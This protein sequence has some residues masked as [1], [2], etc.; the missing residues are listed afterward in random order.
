MQAQTTLWLPAAELYLAGGRL[1]DGIA[2]LRRLLRERLL[3]AEGWDLLANA[4]ERAGRA[5][6]AA[7]AR[8]NVLQ[9]RRD[10]VLVLQR[11][12][13]LAAARH[14]W[15]QAVALAQ[16]ALSKDPSYE[17]VVRDVERFRAAQRGG[18]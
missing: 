11:D 13:R 6:E 15:A 18:R 17:P 7:E 9:A 2:W 5:E 12:A 16:Q 10:Q 8:R 3:W 14:D 1:E 4:C